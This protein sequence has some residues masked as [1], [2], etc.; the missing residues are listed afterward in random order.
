LPFADNSNRL[1]VSGEA[2]TISP[3]DRKIDLSKSFLSEIKENNA[4]MSEPH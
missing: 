3:I 2:R 1:S 4:L